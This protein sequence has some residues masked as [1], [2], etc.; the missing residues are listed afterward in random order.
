MNPIAI[1]QEWNIK[2][3]KE[4]FDYQLKFGNKWKE[5]AC[6]FIGCSEMIAKNQ[7]FSVIRKAL[8]KISKLVKE[9]S[10][11]YDF[12]GTKPAVLCD[13][14]NKIVSVEVNGAK[15]ACKGRD[16][17]EKLV[18]TEVPYISK[19]LT[20]EEKIFSRKILEELKRMKFIN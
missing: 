5:I 12:N 13:F 20:D 9:S 4:L 10:P 1:R 3:W 2:S 19:L 8:R 7:F 16:F 11:V 15:R 17:I 18:F 6:K 14:M